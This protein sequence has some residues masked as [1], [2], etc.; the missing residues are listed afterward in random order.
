MWEADPDPIPPVGTQQT[1]DPFVEESVF[2]IKEISH[3]LSKW[4]FVIGIEQRHGV[5]QGIASEHPLVQ[6]LAAAEGATRGV[7]RQV[8]QLRPVAGVGRVGSQVLVQLGSEGRI[9]IGLGGQGH[10]AAGSQKLDDFNHPGVHRSAELG[11]ASLER[12]GG[13][14]HDTP[15]VRR[16]VGLGCPEAGLQ[17]VSLGD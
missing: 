1:W 10:K 12:G 13:G 17:Y 11:P 9:E 5:P 7:P 2:G 3:L 16:G 14:R 15:L 6:H 8:E 4:F